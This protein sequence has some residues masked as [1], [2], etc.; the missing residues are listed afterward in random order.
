MKDKKE[1]IKIVK[2]GFWAALA[3]I[4]STIALI[5]SIVTFNRTISEAEYQT[6]IKALREKPE[7]MKHETSERISKIRQETTTALEKLGAEIKKQ[8]EK[9]AE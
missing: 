3:L 2:G 5:L 4:F 9:S 7:K 8:T 1:E 6:E